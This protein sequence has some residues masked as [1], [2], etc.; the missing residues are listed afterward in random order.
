MDQVSSKKR[1][2]NH[3]A[4]SLDGRLLERASNL[5]THDHNLLALEI[6]ELLS[7]FRPTASGRLEKI[8]VVL[9]GLKDRIENIESHAP[10]T[11]CSA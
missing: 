4:T 11:V 10:L 7:K 2:I 6:E 9:R 3:P 1:K 8:D 5:P